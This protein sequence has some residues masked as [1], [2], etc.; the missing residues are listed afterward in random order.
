MGFPL[1]TIVIFV[2][3]V[4]IS[5]YMDLWVHRDAKEI[6]LRGSILWSL[7]WIALS[8]CFYGYIYA[9]FGAEPA[10]LFLAGYVLEKTLSID[11]LMVFIA[12]FS[13]FGIKGALQHRILYYGILGAIVFRLIFVAMGNAIMAAGPY[14][15]LLFA[16]IIGYS[17]IKM[18]SGS[19]GGG[20]DDEDEHSDYSS[21]KVVQLAN[22]I[23]TIFPRLD[24][25]KLLISG[26]RARELAAA[27]PAIVLPDGGKATRYATPALVC[28]MV[29]EASDVM[30]AF[31]SVPAVIA[32]TKEPLLVFSAMIFAI[33]GLRSL[34][35]VLA[36]LTKYLVY[37]EKAVMVLLFFIATK[38]ALH[39]TNKLFHW[40]GFEFSPNQSLLIILGVLATGV[41][42]SLLAGKRASSAPDHDHDQA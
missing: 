30:F 40:P 42:A 10:S 22:R 36:A 32:V 6:T 29:I 14:A 25:N 11:N 13:F 31:D 28:L 23:F 7:F 15:D 9:R 26:D 16:A 5:L 3:T 19:L 1:E 38:L 34:Y 20:D 4:L 12:I 18:F 41:V 8:M 24:H 21:H 27:D 33:L 35:F 37:L 17:A 39:A 2:V